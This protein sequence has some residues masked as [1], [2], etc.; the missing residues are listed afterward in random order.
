MDKIEAKNLLQEFINSQRLISYKDLHKRHGKSETIL[1]TGLS[2]AKYQIELQV[3][4][5]DPKQKS[6]LR[7]VAAIDDG[8]FLFFKIYLL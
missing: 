2:G 7:V 6:N 5:D 1:I 3:C 8:S 4:W